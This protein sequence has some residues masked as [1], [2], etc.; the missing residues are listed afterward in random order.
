MAAAAILSKHIQPDAAADEQVAAVIKL[1]GLFDRQIKG[2][3]ATRLSG[4]GTL[5]E[6][7]FA[8]PSGCRYGRHW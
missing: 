7:A 8:R 6:G 3:T 2:G 1:T 4:K 5:R